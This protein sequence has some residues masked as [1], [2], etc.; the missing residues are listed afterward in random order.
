MNWKPHKYQTKAIKFCLERPHAGL[1]LTPGLGKTSIILSVFKILKSQGFEN[2]MLVLAPLR[3]VYSVWPKE[4]Q[5]WDEFS[6]LSVGILHGS[7]KDKV[8]REKHD[9]YCINYEGLSWLKEN[10][11]LLKADMLVVDESS[12]LK[13]TR[14]LRFKTLRPMLPFFKRRYILTG[15]PIAN[16]LLDIFGQ[17]YVMDMGKSLGPRFTHFRDEF[18]IGVGYGGYT[19]VPKP[20]AANKIFKCVAPRVIRMDA[21]DYLDL[22]ELVIKDVEIN[23][24]DKAMKIYKQM[25]KQ[26]RIDLNAGTVTAANAAVASMKCRQLANGGIYTDFEHNWDNIHMEKAEAVGDIVEELSG[27]PAFIS[28]DFA[29]DLGRL[30][31]V[32]GKD[33]PHIG[34][35]VTVKRG[36]EIE[37]DWNKGK[38]P[39]LLG[40]PQSVAHAL[41][42]QGGN[43]GG[44]VILHSIPWSAELCDQFIRRVWRQ[45][46]KRVVVV[47]RLIAKNT[48]DEAIIKALETKNR[49]QNTFFE[50]LKSYLN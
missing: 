26:L 42:L 21:L 5:K 25:E 38:L 1:M 6:K 23:L 19:W 36:R 11:D 17:C 4:V 18:F 7:N 9:I 3:A 10:M 12:K 49:T 16:S 8:L 33:T 46:Q 34:G 37:E 22:P 30:K 24:P 45:G 15:S 28:Y 41:N 20:G 50:A 27:Q 14:T 35:G 13:E 32:L 2:K 31:K 44:A 40:Q 39:C 47:H 48:V 43:D 29:H